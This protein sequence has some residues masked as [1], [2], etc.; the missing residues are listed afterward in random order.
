M[1][2]YIAFWILTGLSFYE[3]FLKSDNSNKL[4]AKYVLPICIA[5]FLIFFAGL[6]KGIG[7]DNNSYEQIY[8]NINSGSFSLF[9]NVV[10]PFFVV[11]NRILPSFQILLFVMAALTVII[12]YKAYCDA[13][14]YLLASVFCFYYGT[15]FLYYDM[16]IMRQGLAMSICLLSLNSI[17]RKEKNFFIYIVVAA[18]F[19]SSAIAFVPLYFL[20]N[21][22]YSRKTYYLLIIISI[23]VFV[24]GYS[25]GGVVSKIINA[26]GKTLI[27][28]K[29]DNF[30]Q[31][32]S[33]T[34]VMPFV[35]R[36]LFGIFFLEIFKRPAV[37]IG[38]AYFPKRNT[39]EYT[40]LFINGY[41]CSIIGW[42]FFSPFINAV[43]GRLTAIYY[44]MYYLIY[45]EI[46][47]DK[48]LKMINLLYFI[49]TVVLLYITFDGTLNNSTGGNFLPYK[50]I[51]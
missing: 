7:I 10:E 41:I 32:D 48:K 37:R 14:I 27:S 47:K 13:G 30:I 50:W 2:Y 24:G 28:Y 5:V 49:I 33:V 38:T 42:G 39:S 25:L 29:F 23:I 26:F 12:R 40:W 43:V 36:V 51:L 20:S 9:N 6:R 19:H 8:N 44:S 17:I 3:I 46:F 22:E 31:Y 15:D 45:M 16:G 18:C 35:R 1:V 11:L 21:K 34:L 4:R